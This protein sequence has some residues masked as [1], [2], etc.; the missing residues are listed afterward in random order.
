MAQ[1]SALA[2]FHAKYRVDDS[3]CWL[4]TASLGQGTGYGRFKVGGVTV[5]AHR[6]LYE[7]TV[8]PVPAGLELDHLCRVRHCVNPDHL[9]PVSH[10]VNMARHESYWAMQTH[11][12]NGHEFTPENIY[13][14]PKAPRRRQC[15][16]C[17]VQALRE[18]RARKKAA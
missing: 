7:L 17:K 8:G 3:G 15:I 1:S 2:R 14:P 11:C 5:R 4:W 12:R 10:A 18:F 9:E 6:W 13:R 16:A